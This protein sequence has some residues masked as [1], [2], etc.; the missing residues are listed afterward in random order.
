MPAGVQLSAQVRNAVLVAKQLEDFTG[1]VK[2]I[3]AGRLFGRMQSV[4]AKLTKAPENYSGTP[5]HHWPEGDKGARARR[6]YFAALR[7]G[8]VNPP[9]QYERSGEYQSS[10]VI[11]KIENG[12]R[13]RSTFP[14]AKYIS[15]NAYGQMQYH[16]HVGRWAALRDETERAMADLPKEIQ[17]NI[18]MVA[19]RKGFENG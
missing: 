15:G 12:Y 2:K 3:S 7:D 8:R 4:Q 19:R 17:E 9:H 18:S 6:W 1:E 5:E 14:A 16:L 13:L 10:W 11:E